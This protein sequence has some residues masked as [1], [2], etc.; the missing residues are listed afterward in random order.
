M[1][2]RLLRLLRLFPLLLLKRR[3]LFCEL[4]LLLRPPLPS[5]AL[6]CCGFCLLCCGRED[7]LSTCFSLL[8]WFAP[9]FGALCS[10]V[11]AFADPLF[12]LTALVNVLTALSSSVDMWFLT[13]MFALF[14]I[15][16]KS[17]DET[18][19]SFANS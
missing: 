5:L 19:K 14:A 17:F 12:F 15:D 7:L 10:V 13:D 9:F 4:R 3:F 18:F 6:F 11:L 2:R 16:T 8:L 1:P